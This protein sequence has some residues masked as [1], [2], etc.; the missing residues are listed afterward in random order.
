M[1]KKFTSSQRSVLGDMVH[2]LHCAL[3]ALG[4]AVRGA[5]ELD[6]LLA[7]ARAAKEHRLVRP[8]V[9]EDNLL[10]ITAGVLHEGCCVRRSYMKP[11]PP[12]HNHNNNDMVYLIALLPIMVVSNAW[13]AFTPPPTPA[14]TSQ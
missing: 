7:L 10:H 9:T 13:C 3:P 14:S 2:K 4:A 6:C 5:A 1:R 11:P 8:Q 12:Q